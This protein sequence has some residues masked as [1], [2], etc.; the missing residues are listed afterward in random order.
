MSRLKKLSIKLEEKNVDNFLVSSSKNIYYLTGF[1]PTT[2][3][4][5][6]YTKGDFILFTTSIDYQLANETIKEI[7]VQ[8]TPLEKSIEQTVAE[9]IKKLEGNLYFEFSKLTHDLYTRF[10]KNKKNLQLL[11][12]DEIINSLRIIKETSEIELIKKAVAIGETGLKTAYESIKEGKSEIE[13]AAEAEYKMRKMGAEGFA[14]D[15]IIISGE[16]TSQPHAKTS[17]IGRAH[18]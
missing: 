7:K 16:R 9:E 3:S 13:V 12:G 10:F 1:Y 8:E 4:Y 6:L 14:F 5:L 17:K 11:N 15:T 2:D 18:V